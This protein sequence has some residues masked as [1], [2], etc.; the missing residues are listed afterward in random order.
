M[1]IRPCSG[2]AKGNST[3]LPLISSKCPGPRSMRRNSSA[4]INGPCVDMLRPPLRPQLD[5]PRHRLQLYDRPDLRLHQVLATVL[6]QDVVPRE[7]LAGRALALAEEVDVDPHVL[8]HRPPEI[9]LE[10]LAPS[11][12]SCPSP[13]GLLEHG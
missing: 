2:R 6:E 5:G 10:M 9:G 12:E 13:P 7:D 8:G 4:V 1:Q 3:S 11:I